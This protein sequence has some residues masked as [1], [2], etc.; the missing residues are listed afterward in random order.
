M[1]SLLPEELLS[2]LNEAIRCRELQIKQTACLVASDIFSPPNLVLHGTEATGKSLTI[3]AL[4]QATETPSA[5]VRSKECITTRHLLERTLTEVQ[6]AS[7]DS[8]PSIDGRCESI[9]TFVVQLQRLL[10]G[11][12]KFIL[13]FDNIDCQ[14]EP[15]PTLLPALARLGELIP[16]LTTVFIISFRRPSLFHKPGIPHI[17]YPPYTRAELL[18]LISSCPLPLQCPSSTSPPPNAPTFSQADLD[19]LWPR[20]ATAVHDSLA[21]P[22]SNSLPS[23][24]TLCARLW[25]SFIAP[26]LS[27]QYSPREFSKLM[28]RNRHFFQSEDVLKAS[29]IP[30][31]Q[32]SHSQQQTQ[33]QSQQQSQ[34]KKSTTFSLPTLPAQLLITAYLASYTAPKHDTLLF[35]KYSTSRRKRRGGGTMASRTP[36][37]KT[38]ITNTNRKISR[39]AMLGAQAFPLERMLAIY[40]ALFRD[41]DK[42]DESGDWRN[43]RKRKRGGQGGGAEELTMFMTLVGM[44]LVVRAG[45]GSAGE[46][47]LAEGGGKWRVNVG[48]EYVRQVARGLRFD[49]DSYL[50]E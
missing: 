26:V 20:F 36:N 14:R 37:K 13:V 35:S 18:T 49:L 28:V 21:Q 2:S 29:I 42:G 50:L 12:K 5:I 11:Q 6:H 1:D 46:D 16:N 7:G 47:P 17:H 32:Q 43:G 22:A 27:N 34:L 10:E 40:S 24:R 39:I 30:L 41:Y 23:F 9:S 4:L 38:T 3:N 25:P 44:G 8:A 19:Y 48:R 31:P 15:A 33:P 45:V